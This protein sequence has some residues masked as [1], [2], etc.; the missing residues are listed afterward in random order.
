[1]AELIDFKPGGLFLDTLICLLTPIG[2]TDKRE[3]D[4]HGLSA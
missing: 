3:G 2:R 4:G 1:M